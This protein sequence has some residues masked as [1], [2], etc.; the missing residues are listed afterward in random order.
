MELTEEKTLE[1]EM[2]NPEE[3]PNPENPAE[4]GL[5]EIPESNKRNQKIKLMKIMTWL[6]KYVCM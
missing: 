3:N 2:T 5:D 1:T 4:D 6:N